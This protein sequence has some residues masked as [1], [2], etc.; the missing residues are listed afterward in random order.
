MG[1]KK[2]HV[3]TPK[4]RSCVLALVDGGK[5][6]IREISRLL[7]IPKSTVSDIK[8]R[9]TPNSKPKS[10]RSSLLSK[11]DKRRLDAYI[12]QSRTTRQQTSES[13]IKTLNLP[14]G[15]TTLITALHELGYRRCVACHRCLLKEIDYKRRLIFAR[16]YRHFTVKDWKRVIF[17]DEM[18][19]KVGMNRLSIMWI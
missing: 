5:H 13:I 9:G 10:G 4:K 14:I 2:T 3:W 17:T 16:K 1:A 12:K 19:I 7:N 18:S 8:Q 15:R 11:H 6:S